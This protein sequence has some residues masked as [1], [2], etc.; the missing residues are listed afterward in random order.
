M[1][2]SKP[3]TKNSLLIMAV[4]LISVVAIYFIL[5]PSAPVYGDGIC[6]VTENCL[7]N[8]KDCKCSQGEYCSHTK[9]ECVLPICGNGVC[10]SFENSNTC[11][12]DCSCALEQENC[13]KKTHKCELP[14][15]GISDETVTKLISQYFNS[16][17]KDIEKISKIKTDVFENEI[18]KS[19]EVIITGEDRTY[20]IVVNANGKIT[21]VPIYQ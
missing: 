9:K 15:I 6:D 2:D 16:Q 1:D 11:C 19:A 4:V 8:P 5:K 3:N 10:E 18:V 13:N 7:D 17:E 21:E 14:D 12:N 20:L